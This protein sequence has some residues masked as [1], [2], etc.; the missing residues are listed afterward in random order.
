MDMDLAHQARMDKVYGRMK[1]VYDATRPL[2]LAG[3]RRLRATVQPAGDARILEV[4]CGTARNLILLARKWPQTSLVGIDISSEMLSYARTKVDQA[5]LGT[6]IALIEAELADALA[7]T[8]CST[9]FDYVVFSYSLSMIPDWQTVLRQA[10][11]LVKPDTGKLLIADFGACEAWPGPVARRLYKNLSHFAVMPRPELVSFLT[12]EPIGGRL[13][14]RQSRLLGG[15]GQMIEVRR[16]S[17]LA[18]PH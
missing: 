12:S 7:T 9:P 11:P 14:V 8:H 17:V 1:Y 2:F 5:G 4:G 18:S 16:T 3:R 6:R 10:L 13:D 15:Y